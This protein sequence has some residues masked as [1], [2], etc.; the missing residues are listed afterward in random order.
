MAT[1]TRRWSSR[2]LVVV[3]SLVLAVGLAVVAIWWFTGGLQAFRDLPLKDRLSYIDEINPE[4]MTAEVCTEARGLCEEGWR[5]AVGDFQRF[6]SVGEAEYWELV[7]GNDGLR[8][9]KVI[10]NMTEVVLSLEEKRM[11]V[12]VLFSDRDWT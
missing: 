5:T 11:A 10:L 9:G 1:P 6:A 2:R 12:D 7:L 4:E 3:V 8:N